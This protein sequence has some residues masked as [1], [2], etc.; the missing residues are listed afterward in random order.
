[1]GHVLVIPYHGESKA[2]Q[3]S[4]FGDEFS[5]STVTGTDLSPIQ[6][7]WVPP[8]VKFEIDDAQLDW[9]WNENYF[10]F[11]H[12]RCLMGSIKDWPRLYNQAFCCTK[13]GGYIEHLDFDIQFTSDDGTVKEG[14]TMYDWSKIFIDA[15][16]DITHQ[17]FKIPRF[18]AQLIKEAGFVDVVEKK[19]KIPVGSWMADKKLKEIG[20]WN[21]LFL[22]TGL[23]GM[24]LWMLKHVLGVIEAK[25]R[26][27]L[28]DRANHGYYEA[29]LVYGRKPG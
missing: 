8:N 9:T 6:P 15:A 28:L 5:S 2:D 26:A 27:A 21:L 1:M 11:I 13:P 24:Q 14:D 7:T 18:S 16:E 4:D 25:M 29:T 22:T 3:A 19:F 12:I 23:Q 10:D 20:R 17:T